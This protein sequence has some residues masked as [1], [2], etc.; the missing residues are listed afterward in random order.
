MNTNKPKMWI[1]KITPEDSGNTKMYFKNLFLKE[2]R[3]NLIG[4]T[5]ED[6]EKKET[7][8][9]HWGA[10][11]KG[12]LVVVLGGLS[13]VFGVV[14]ITSDSFDETDEKKLNSSDDWFYHRRKAE[15]VEYF[16]PPLVAKAQTSRNTI[17]AYSSSGA[18]AICDEVWDI[19]KDEY[20][21]RP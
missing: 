16:N 2:G 13:K 1:M 21:D 19:I 14:K 7:F 20:I 6:G 3:K 8:K 4:Y 11:K 12:D 10:I 15:L 18:V 5:K 9:Q 17:I